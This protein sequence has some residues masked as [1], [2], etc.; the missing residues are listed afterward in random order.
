MITVEQNVRELEEK[1]T[2]FLVG[3]GVS[4]LYLLAKINA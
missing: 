4:G 3:A 2:C 1:T